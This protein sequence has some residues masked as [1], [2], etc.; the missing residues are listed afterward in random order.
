MQPII[1]SIILFI[2]GLGG[3]EMLLLAVLPFLLWIW[4]IVDLMQGRFSDNTLRIVWVLLI[5]FLP[6]IGSILYLI[7]GRSQKLT[8]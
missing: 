4:A 1:N 8:S 5:I 3:W 7:I 2:G 6:V